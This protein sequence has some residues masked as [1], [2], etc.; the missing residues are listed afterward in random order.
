MGSPISSTL[1]DIFLQSF[2]ELTIK[3]W[4]ESGEILY[5]TRYLDDILIILD[6]NKTKE[7]S[8]TPIT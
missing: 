8:I 3:Q 1:A 4:R 5:Y 2:E 6:Q 7:D